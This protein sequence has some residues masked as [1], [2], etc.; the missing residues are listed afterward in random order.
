MSIKVILFDL[1]GTL[2][3]MDQ[4][5]FIKCYFGKLAAKMEP[6]G[7]EPKQ[8]LTDIWTC[9]RSMIKN[10]GRDTNENVFWNG[11]SGIYG[12]KL[13]KDK[14]VFDEFYQKDFDSVKESCGFNP[15]AAPTVRAIKEK[16][17]RV[18]LA[19][20]PIIPA[21]ATQCRIRWTGLEPSDFELYTT[22]ENSSYAK[23]NLEYYKE[24]LAKLDVKPEECLMVGNDVNEDMVTEMLGMKVFLMTE[25]IINRDNKEISSYPQGGFK[26]LLK[27]LDSETL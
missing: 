13:E 6:Y 2:L 16:G 24:I 14:P 18:V 15:E 12:E 25:C 8:L 22:Y 5:K 9:T 10:D 20:N 4:E 27:F 1:D 7:Y 3:P 23:P 21:I 26:E 11:F 19:T 17:Y